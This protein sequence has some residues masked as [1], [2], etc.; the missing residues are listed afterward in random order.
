MTANKTIN[1]KDPLWITTWLDTALRKE[2]EKYE[3]CPVTSDM[4]PPTEAAQ[5]WGYV[6]AGYF[7]VEEAFK[8]LLYVRG[9]NVPRGHSLSTLFELFDEGDKNVLREYYDDYRATIGGNRGVFPFRSLDNFLLNLDGDKNERGDHI[10]SFD[11]RY[12]LLEEKRSQDMPLVSVDYLHEIVYGCIRVVEY[13]HHGSHE[14]L[15]E[16]HS[17]RMRF[18]RTE[19]YHDW[20]TVRINSDGWDDLGDRLEILWGPDYRGRYDLCLFRGNRQNGLFSA[21]PDNFDM[22]IIDKRK[23]IEAFDVEEGF[24]SI[25]VNRASP[26]SMS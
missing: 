15:Q 9:E 18:E 2:K 14:P 3:K 6:I 13:A 25:G 1:F 20:L 21:I 24:R 10:G 22:R 11:W 26:T 19:K 5:G 17:W 7:L 23:E 8:A 16:T 12:F 4:Y